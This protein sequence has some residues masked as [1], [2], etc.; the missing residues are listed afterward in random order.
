LSALFTTIFAKLFGKRRT[1]LP[2]IIVNSL[3]SLMV[4]L[5]ASVVRAALNCIT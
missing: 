3:Y 5:S 1:I 4:G 2:V